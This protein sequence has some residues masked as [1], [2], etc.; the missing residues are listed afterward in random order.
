MTSY[1]QLP[2]R[3]LMRHVGTS[4]EGGGGAPRNLYAH[5]DAPRGPHER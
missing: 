5:V 4:E 3:A 2:D 1:G